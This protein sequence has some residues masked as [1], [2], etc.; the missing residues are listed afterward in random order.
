MPL[1]T[2]TEALREMQRL[3]QTSTG[4]LRGV[5][6]RHVTHI[7]VA[8]AHLQGT[9][10]P[11]HCRVLTDL[12]ERAAGS[13]RPDSAEYLVFSDDLLIAVLTVVARVVLPDYPL[14]PLQ[15]RHQTAAADALADLP[16]PSLRELADQRSRM[17]GRDDQ[18]RL[19]SHPAA[20]AVRIA[21]SDDPTVTCWVTIDADLET[22]QTSIRQCGL[23]PDHLIVITAPG[24]GRYGRDRHRLQ[25]PILSAMQHLADRHQ[26]PAAVVGDWLDAEGATNAHP[27]PGPEQ[28]LANFTAAYIGPFASELDYTRH[29]MTELGWIAALEHTGIPTR[30]LDE[31]AVN[32]DWFRKQ[33]RGISRATH[34]RIDVFHRTTATP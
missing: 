25:V 17:D 13:L 15:R 29:H 1:S 23:D 31:A 28:I 5:P 26:L 22:C 34:N 18:T 12:A 3:E 6:A 19:E 27:G 21:A 32:R 2:N 11:W 4:R 24:Y 20:G 14:S 8:T 9:A 10:E 30:Y 16:R 33:V 7:R